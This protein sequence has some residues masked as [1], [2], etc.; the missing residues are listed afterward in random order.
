MLLRD[1]IGA[2]ASPALLHQANIPKTNQKTLKPKLKTRLYCS[3]LFIILLQWGLSKKERCRPRNKVW[4]YQANNPGHL[5]WRVTSSQTVGQSVVSWKCQRNRGGASFLVRFHFGRDHAIA[6]DRV[7]ILL[8]P[9]C[10]T[11]LDGRSNSMWGRNIMAA[12]AQMGES[13]KCPCCV[14][15]NSHFIKNYFNVK[16]LVQPRTSSL[17]SLQFYG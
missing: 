12:L 2:S 16:I 8:L 10:H 6:H 17:R 15:A 11:Q 13:W 14:F 3:P 5:P 1:H 9:C 7:F 4:Q